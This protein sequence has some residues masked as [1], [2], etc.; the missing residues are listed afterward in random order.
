MKI[1]QKQS[2]VLGCSPWKQY[3]AVIKY[4]QIRIQIPALPLCVTL[5]TW[6]SLSS[7]VKQ[8]Y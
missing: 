5:A 8:G 2:H 1:S 3:D 6:T 4:R 7:S